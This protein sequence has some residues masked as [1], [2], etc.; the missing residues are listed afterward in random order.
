MIKLAFFTRFFSRCAQSSSSFAKMFFYVREARKYIDNGNYVAMY[1]EKIFV[2]VA[3]LMALSIYR[4]KSLWPYNKH[5][6]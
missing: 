5:E 4:I 6:F 3:F 1:R 2:S